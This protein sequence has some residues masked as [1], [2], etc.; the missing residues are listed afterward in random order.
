MNA[1]KSHTVLIEPC[2]GGFVTVEVRVYEDA[3]IEL[4]FDGQL[5]HSRPALSRVAV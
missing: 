1:L 5:L 2:D 3:W 4:F